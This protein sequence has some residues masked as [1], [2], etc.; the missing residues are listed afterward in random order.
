MRH[1]ANTTWIIFFFF[2]VWMYGCGSDDTVPQKEQEE[3]LPELDKLVIRSTEGDL[4]DLVGSNTTQLSVVG[5]DQ[6][7]KVFDLSSD[8]VWTADND[9]VMLSADGE[10]SGVASGFSVIKVVA[11]GFQE[12]FEI[13][14]WDSSV[15]RTDIYVSDVGA[16][17]NGPHEIIVYRGHD[18]NAVTLIST[19]LNRP[20][21]IIFLEEENTMLVS[22]LGSNDINKFDIK[23]GSYKGSFATGLA[24]PTRM[25][26]GP[27]NLLYVISWQGA[28]VKRYQ[29]DGTFVDDFGPSVDQAIGI[30]WDDSGNLYLSSFNDGS[31]GFVKKF[32]T[33]GKDLGFFINT[34][35]IGP[36]DIWFDEDGNMLV[37]DWSGSTVEKF[38]ASGVHSETFIS[39][40]GAPEGVDFMDDGSILI[41]A[42]GNGSVR[43][44]DSQGDFIEETVSSKAGGLNTP[45]AVK[46]RKVNQ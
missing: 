12:E 21:D 41:G 3:E 30:A 19:N 16:N 39:N 9:N 24:Q 32:D 10:V 5:L 27:D 42:S 29:L 2:S 14:V 45:N 13:Q 17:R 11:D 38:D 40:V 28:S 8:P 4:L 36:T 43:R 1:L 25:A 26:I 34:N 44:Y 33:T 37:N 7:G 31:N 18:K 23:N 20:Q 22:N 46:I 35:L 6:F 15:P